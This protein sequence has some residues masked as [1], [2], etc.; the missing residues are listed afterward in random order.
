[1]LPPSQECAL[2]SPFVIFGDVFV[3]IIKFA[4]TALPCYNW[5]WLS[6]NHIVKK[7]AFLPER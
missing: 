2:V 6:N 4:I 7:K 5:C 3:R 1:M